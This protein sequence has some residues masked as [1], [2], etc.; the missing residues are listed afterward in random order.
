MKKLL[1]LLFLLFLLSS[2]SVFA[3]D[4]SD[5]TIEGISIGDS[6]LDYMT[7]DEILEEIEL[8]ISLNEYYYLK[9][10]LKYVHVYLYNYSSTFEGNLSFLLKN[11]PSSKYISKKND[12]YII[13][14]IRGMIDF[15][16]DL[17]GCMKKRDEIV[18]ELSE[19]FPNER[20][21]EHSY[22][23]SEDP[24]GKSMKYDVDF[25]FNSGDEIEI[26]CDNYEETYRKKHNWSEGLNVA[27]YTSETMNWLRDY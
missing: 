25:I 26:S 15:I 14:S 18:K 7:E 21:S 24:S 22:S 19:M 8:S 16:E 23:D 9:E 2:P 10:P 20:K 1:A 4:I 6:L 27:I 3:D 12:K 5:F 17:D 11:T 13:Q